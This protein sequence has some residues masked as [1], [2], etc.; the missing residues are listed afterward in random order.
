MVRAFEPIQ[1]RKGERREPFGGDGPGSI[2]H[3]TRAPDAL[4]D[5]C[6]TRATIRTGG[7]TVRRTSSGCS[8]R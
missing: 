7:S 8:W 4:G 3:V 5:G 1:L 6:E 2:D